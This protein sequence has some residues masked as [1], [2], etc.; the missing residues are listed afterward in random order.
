MSEFYSFSPPS[1]EA[2][3][4]SL[5]PRRQP[6]PQSCPGVPRV[7]L[8]ALPA[9]S[10]AAAMLSPHTAVISASPTPALRGSSERLLQH[11][12]A[13]FFGYLLIFWGRRKSS[14]ISTPGRDTAGR[15]HL[16]RPSLWLPA[17]A[18]PCLANAAF[19]PLITVGFCCN[20]TF[21]RFQIPRIRE[22]E[23]NAGCDGVQKGAC[24]YGHFYGVPPLWSWPCT[25]P[26]TASQ[27]LIMKDVS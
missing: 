20:L 19:Y 10:R 21:V 7:L 24:I 12:L 25:P 27:W 2:A 17:P 9:P 1:S 15:P 26:Q 14:D 11:H 8:P 5:C 23:S 3:L 22:C 18:L 13:L 6:S 4:Y 16:P